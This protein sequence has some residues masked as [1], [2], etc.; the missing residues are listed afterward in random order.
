MPY[1]GER[2]Q[3]DS[4]ARMISIDPEETVRGMTQAVL[5][6]RQAAAW[7]AAQEEIDPRAIGHHGHQ[8]GRHHRGAGGQHRAALQQ[9]LPA[10]GRRRHGR[11]GLDL[12]RNGPLA[13]AL[14]RVG[15]HARKS[16]SPCS[17][18][19]TR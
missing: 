4:P 3:P 13:Q 7:L 18:S 17:R 11:S 8:P 19:S 2:R 16:C 9:G 14:G 12:D 5:D 10:A 1:Y 6:I 15:R